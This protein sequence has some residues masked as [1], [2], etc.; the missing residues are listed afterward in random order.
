[1]TATE[2]VPLSEM[3]QTL[4]A[5][6]TVPEVKLLRD[7]AATIQEYVRRQCLG[8]QRQNNA[9]EMKIRCERR[10]GEMLKETVR[11]EGTAKR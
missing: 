1:M 8:L 11:H 6:Q 9:A 4:A 2:L 3:R 10:L 5:A 7:Q